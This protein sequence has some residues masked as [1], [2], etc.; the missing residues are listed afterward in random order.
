MSKSIKILLLIGSIIRYVCLY[1]S[2]YGFSDQ[3]LLGYKVN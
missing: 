3:I 2:A 1:I